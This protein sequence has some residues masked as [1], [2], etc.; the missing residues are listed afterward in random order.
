MTREMG[1]HGDPSF[2]GRRRRRGQ[3]H[4]YFHKDYHERYVLQNGKAVSPSEI[5]GIE[6]ERKTHKQIHQRVGGRA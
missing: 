5:D 1:E 3:E 2:V 6:R 4:I